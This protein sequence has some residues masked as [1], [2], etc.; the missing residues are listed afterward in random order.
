M[1]YHG[2]VN[3]LVD[4]KVLDI[5]KKRE[6]SSAARLGYTKRIGFNENDFISVCSNMGEEVYNTGVNNAF[7]KYI[8][9]NFCF[10]IDDSIEVEKPEYIPNA[11]KM[12]TLELFNLKRNNPNKRFSDIIDEYQVKDYISFDKVVAI[13]VPYGLKVQDGEIILSNFCYLK[14]EEFLELI[15]KVEKIAEEL[16]IPVVDSSSKEFLTMFDGEKKIK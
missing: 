13:G 3:G 2:V 16:G 6:I 1:Y 5:L 10:V 11:S 9:N 15:G 14:P 12:G 8:K 7:N 4:K